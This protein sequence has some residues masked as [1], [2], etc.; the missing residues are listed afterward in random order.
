MK[1]NG[2]NPNL[3][4]QSLSRRELLKGAGVAGLLLPTGILL[5]A[6][7]SAAEGTKGGHL[8]LGL[9]GGS[10]TDSLDPATWADT[11]MIMVGYAVR[12]NLVE[13]ASDGSAVGE[14][15]ESF[16]ASDGAKKWAFKL[17]TG[18]V[19]SDGK[20]V[21]TAD[22]ISSINY[23]RDES[24]KSG[25]KSLLQSI[26]D[27][28]VEGNDTIVFTLSDGNADFPFVLADY[29]LNIMPFAE[30]KP[31]FEVGAGPYKIEK[32]EPGVRTV[33]VRN[34][35]SHKQGNVDTVE[36][37]SIADSTA[38][39]NALQAGDVDVINR[40]DVKTVDF[41]AA[42]AGIKVE[43]VPGRL[44]YNLPMITKVDPFT[45]IDVRL[46]LKYSIDRDAILKTILNGHGQIGN[47]QP[48]TPSYRFYAKDLAPRPYDP[49]KAKFHMKKSGL[50][51][52]Q[53]DLSA[54][55][56]AFPGAVDAA[57]LYAEQAAKAGIKINVVREPND[58]YWDNVWLRKPFCAAYWGGRP[59][60][61]V[62]LTIAY[63]KG[64]PWNEAQWENSRFNE[65]LVGA[66]GE[67][68]EGKR[69]GMYE[70]MQHIVSD[71]GGNI[72]P[73]FANHVHAIS[74]KVG[75][76]DSVSGVW[77]LDGARCIERWWIG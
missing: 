34:S 53:I 42:V 11:Y 70:E 46:A 14:I 77:E 18:I 74:A 71:D 9:A 17:R 68:D 10:T 49:E 37:L 45:N 73:V 7:P 63:A 35:Q 39:Q 26:A 44:H 62:M 13:V 19:F 21:S 22:V 57:V 50:S 40:A 23:H 38:R 64:A 5:G 2:T 69:R 60:E 25:A 56:A 6:G 31:N 72:I 4:A 76:S 36:M 24:S 12:G 61:D 20:S 33:L 54:A 66:R 59:T 52:I 41:L 67:L 28:T 43:D 1:L 75:H 27:I 30:G 32:F 65:L 55:D 29:H 15:A 8:R 51:S 48:I 58:G 47:D 16:E 3:A